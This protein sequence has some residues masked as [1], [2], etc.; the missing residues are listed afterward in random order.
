MKVNTFRLRFPLYMWGICSLHYTFLWMKMCQFDMRYITIPLPS[1]H[2]LMMYLKWMTNSDLKSWDYIDT[3]TT[4]RRIQLMGKWQ[5]HPSCRV[6]GT[7]CLVLG[8]IFNQHS[9]WYWDIKWFL[10]IQIYD[11]YFLSWMMHSW[12]L[13][14]TIQCLVFLKQKWHEICSFVKIL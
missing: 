2:P 9:Q 3:Y 4:R 5:H 12:I 11:I 14:T 13:I 6:I 1:D 7:I 8:L 10:P